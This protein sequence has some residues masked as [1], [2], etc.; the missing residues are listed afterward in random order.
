MPA[1]TEWT[2]SRGCVT[3]RAKLR[4]KVRSWQQACDKDDTEPGGLTVAIEDA[5]RKLAEMPR[6][7]ERLRKSGLRKLSRNDPDA[8][9]LRCR[10][11]FELGY[12]G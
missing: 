5:E 10:R 3:K 6:R 12:T 9:F 4:R 11:G 8:R 7:L 2:R 1:G